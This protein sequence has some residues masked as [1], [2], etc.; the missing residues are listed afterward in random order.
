M[1]QIHQETTVEL[2]R[3]LT[4]GLRQDISMPVCRRYMDDH[5]IPVKKQLSQM[6]MAEV[7]RFR[8]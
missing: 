3:I 4:Q 5:N 6:M 8:I 7:D 1:T 2:K